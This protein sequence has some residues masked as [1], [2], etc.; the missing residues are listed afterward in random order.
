MAPSPLVSQ[1]KALGDSFAQLKEEYA[2][3][4]KGV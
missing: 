2:A 4:K 1:I 3:E